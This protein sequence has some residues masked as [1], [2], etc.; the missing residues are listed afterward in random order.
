MGAA[1]QQRHRARMTWR[2]DQRGHRAFFDDAAC[3]H[4]RDAVG[5]LDGSA[6]VVRDEDDREAELA[7]QLAQQQGL[8]LHGRVQRRGRLVGQQQL[9]L[10]GERQGDH[11]ALPH[12]ARHLVRIRVETPLGARDA[13]ALEQRER[14]LPCFAGRDRLVAP[15]RLHDLRA[16]RIHRVECQ[17]WLLENHRSDLAAE[18]DELRAGKLEHVL[19]ADLDAAGDRRAAFV[20]QPQER[21]QRDA[22]ARTR[23]ADQRDDLAALHPQVDAADRMHRLAAAGERHVE[24]LDVD[25]SRLGHA[26]TSIAR[27]AERPLPPADSGQRRDLAGRPRS[28]DVAR[29]LRGLRQHSAVHTAF[30]RRFPENYAEAARRPAARDGARHRQAHGDDGV[31]PRRHRP[32]A[33]Q[34]DSHAARR[35]RQ[36]GARLGVGGRERRGQRAG[37]GAA[38]AAGSRQDGALV[39]GGVPRRP[40]PLPHRQAPARPGADDRGGRDGVVHV[41]RPWALAVQVG[42]AVAI[43]RLL[44]PPPRGLQ[45][46]AARLTARAGRGGRDRVRMGLQR[47]GVLQPRVPPAVPASPR[48]WRR[49]GVVSA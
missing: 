11:R 45:P 18:I 20:V 36:P 15:D 16:D 23:F 22:L 6:D 3:V 17:Q 9:R 14:A 46:R 39:D 4:H 49:H 29:R 24:V 42:A 7:L 44:E 5:D 1:A 43:A 40:H 2:A 28:G 38:V 19:R 31:G 21:A 32:P 27:A 10:A 13:H 48:A 8:D 12:A 37:R 26:A 41:G 35:G 30:R 33:D 47:G 34:H 25:E